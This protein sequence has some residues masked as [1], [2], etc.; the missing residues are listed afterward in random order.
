[1]LKSREKED[2]PL[3]IRGRLFLGDKSK[4]ASY[5]SVDVY[6]LPGGKKIDTLVADEDG[7]FGTSSLEAGHYALVAKLIPIKEHSDTPPYLV[8]DFYAIQSR[9]ISVYPWSKDTT[10]ELDVKIIEYGRVTFE[11]AKPFPQ[12]IEID[13][14]VDG[15]NRKVTLYPALAVAIPKDQSIEMLPIRRLSDSQHVDWPITG[16]AGRQ[17]T[18]HMLYDITIFNNGEYTNKQS[19]PVGKPI[20]FPRVPTKWGVF[21]A[22]RY[23][24]GAYMTFSYSIGEVPSEAPSG[25]QPAWQIIGES[26]LSTLP[27]ESR[28]S[29]EVANHRRTHLRITPPDDLE[30]ALREAVAQTDGELKRLQELQQK[31]LAVKLEVVGQ[32]EL[33][34]PQEWS[35]A[36]QYAPGYGG[37]R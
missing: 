37:A 1:L 20:A 36:P 25:I 19:V 17:V 26:N 28:A 4:P 21:T 30:R 29:F 18:D 22:G 16:I 33:F 15:L 34:D 24:A 23:Q 31:A 9:P 7:R 10:V 32:A 5:A 12:V 13:L 35:P 27:S 11:L 2:R 3:A 8:P 14:L 6:P